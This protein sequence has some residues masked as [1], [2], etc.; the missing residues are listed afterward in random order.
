MRSSVVV[1][2]LVLLASGLACGP[3]AEPA[4]VP[5]VT[6]SA[7]GAGANANANASA[8]ANANANA[9]STGSGGGGGSGYAGHG[10]DSVPPEVIARYAPTPLAGDVSRRIQAMLDV[11]A[12]VGARIA[13]DGSAVYFAWTVTGTAQVWK[14]DATDVAVD[15]ALRDFPWR[16][17]A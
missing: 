10:A 5:P 9:K 3:A 7:P 1:G 11:R 12:P 6:A 16:S 15:A 14:V 4:R 17:T 8:N 2:A 13:P